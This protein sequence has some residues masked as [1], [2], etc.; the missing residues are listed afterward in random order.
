MWQGYSQ[1]R[2]ELS[3]TNGVELFNHRLRLT[4]LVDHKSGYKVLNSEQQFLCQ[5]SAS[6]KDISSLVVPTWRQ[7]R[8]VANRFTPVQTS[9][10]YI[11]DN[12]FTRIR[13]V[14][15]TYN[16]SDAFIRKYA[17]AAGASI[18]LGIRNIAVYTDWTGVDPEQNYSQGDTQST[19]LTAGPPRYYTAR[20]NLRY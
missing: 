8:A 10:G 14:S 12:S 1:P 15:A 11:E 2:V 4:A 3:L 6:C 19:L 18:N 7:A 9:F 13:E 17:R 16:F 20:I 5:Q